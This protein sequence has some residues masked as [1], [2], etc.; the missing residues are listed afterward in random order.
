MV[1]KRNRFVLT[2]QWCW[3]NTSLAALSSTMHEIWLQKSKSSMELRN[4]KKTAYYKQAFP[5]YC[6]CLTIFRGE[7]VL[8][9]EKAS[10]YAPIYMMRDEFL[11]PVRLFCCFFVPKPQSLH[12]PG[13]FCV[14]RVLLSNLEARAGQFVLYPSIKQHHCV[15]VCFRDW[16]NC[17]NKTQSTIQLNDDTRIRTDSRN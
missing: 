12:K 16:F 15:V 7:R 5:C 3:I 10:S 2:H 6:R 14:Y 9:S 1:S 11:T 17:V 8:F 4:F 13:N